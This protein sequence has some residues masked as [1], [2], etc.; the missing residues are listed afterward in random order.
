[1][2]QTILIS[3]QIFFHNQ[4]KNNIINIVKS[5]N[6]KLIRQ[7]HVLFKRRFG[8]VSSVQF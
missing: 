8:S 5:K 7:I 4:R 6:S 3:Q 2:S 1:M